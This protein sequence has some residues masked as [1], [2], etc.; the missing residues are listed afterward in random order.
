VAF[1]F[2]ISP[3][4]RMW[5]T[6][7]NEKHRPWL[8]HHTRFGVVCDDHHNRQHNWVRMELKIIQT[9]VNHCRGTQY[10]LQEFTRAKG[11]LETL[12]NNAY[13]DRQRWMGIDFLRERKRDDHRLH[14]VFEATFEELGEWRVQTNVENL[15]DYHH[16]TFSYSDRR[17]TSK[18]CT[19]FGSRG[20][21]TLSLGLIHSL[22]GRRTARGCLS[23]D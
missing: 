7:A 10:I 12:V 6:F 8:W 16:I 14:L 9:N 17:T 22:D 18:A 20:G 11:I 1:S 15:S 3:I 21:G 13:N 19:A 5:E 4:L 23:V 2:K